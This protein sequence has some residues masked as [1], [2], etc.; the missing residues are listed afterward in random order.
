MLRIALYHHLASGGA[1]RLVL[2][3]TRRSRHQY[4]WFRVVDDDQPDI[5]DELASTVSEICS[6]TL[7]GQA[8]R[9]LVTL[10]ILERKIARAIDAGAFDVALVYPC[11]VFQ[12]PG[13]L[14]H[15][16]TPSVY[17]APEVR[18]GSFE[19][20]YLPSRWPRFDPRTGIWSALQGALGIRERRNFR[21][22][23]A[24]ATTSRFSA[25]IIQ[26]VHGRTS[27]VCPPGVDGA[28]F[29]YDGT[30]RSG[31]YVLAVGGLERAKRHGAVVTALASIGEPLRPE[32]MI[33][34]QRG[35]SRDEQELLE[36][37]RRSNVRVSLLRDVSVHEVV[38]I[39]QKAAMTVCAA[40]LEPFGLTTL[41]S[42]ACGTPVVA[43]NRGGYREVLSSGENGLLVE[44]D[45]SSIAA[46]IQQVL[47]RDG[48][49]VPEATRNE[50]VS[51]WT[52][53]ECSRQLD[54]LCE[55]TVERE[56]VE[57]N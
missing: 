31:S 56:V 3:A 28:T 7:N 6:L 2:E 38:A 44:P 25:E 10:P 57:C 45:P 14:S 5:S 37:A 17:Y 48:Q 15:V 40:T 21:E 19:S 30:S 43:V 50:M 1:A 11:R 24:I 27:T 13:V 9:Q 46:G 35:A 51:K 55:R 47:G 16:T 4:T 20:G 8:G 53:N 18:R 23:S 39:Y 42:I 34:C 29:T 41:E 26:F 22:A 12:T 54:L 33:V 36:Q 32:L 49:A 52:W